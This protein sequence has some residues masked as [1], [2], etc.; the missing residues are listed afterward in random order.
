METT[1]IAFY[2]VVVVVPLALLA[3][4]KAAAFFTAP[5]PPLLPIATPV[6]IVAATSTAA[7]EIP[8]SLDAA[9]PTDH[10]N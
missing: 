8:A 7:P 10:A 1:A 9:S 4:A 3:V 6:A 5:V 2:T